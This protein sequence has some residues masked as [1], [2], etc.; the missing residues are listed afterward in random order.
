MP[1]YSRQRELIRQNL[2]SRTDH[3]TAEM[4][5]EDVKKVLPNI[6][7]GTVYRNLTMLSEQ[8]EILRLAM[9]EGPDRFDGNSR[10]HAH[11]LCR[12]CG[13]YW[14]I[15]ISNP[16]DLIQSLVRDFDGTADTG[17]VA[18]FGICGKCRKT[19]AV[20]NV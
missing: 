9:P 14:D 12:R 20:I 17:H 6:S 11:F 19:E 16:D 4:V 8:G 18:L 5:L 2:M 7:L 3:P 1:N 15:P 13:G 10:P